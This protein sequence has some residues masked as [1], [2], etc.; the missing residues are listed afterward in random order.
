MDWLLGAL[1]AFIAF[2]VILF[3]ASEW[4]IWGMRC[5]DKTLEQRKR[6]SALQRSR[7]DYDEHLHE[8]IFFR[9]PMRLYP[10]STANLKKWRS[11]MRVRSA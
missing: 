11:W 9:D 4:C 8:L 6:L 7:V 2:V 5:N 1:I 10:A 3:L